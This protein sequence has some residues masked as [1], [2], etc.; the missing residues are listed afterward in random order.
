MAEVKRTMICKMV[1]GH[2]NYWTTNKKIKTTHNPTTQK[3][4]LIA[5]CCILV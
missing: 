4:L 2:V 5:F 3:I 1:K